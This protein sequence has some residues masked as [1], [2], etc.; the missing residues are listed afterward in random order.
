ML[1]LALTEEDAGRAERFFEIAK[2]MGMR[3]KVTLSKE[4]QLFCKF[5]SAP[6]KMQVFR[7]E[8]G[9]RIILCKSCGKIRKIAFT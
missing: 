9:K 6:P 2:K 7:T 5:C 1:Q 8:D 3:N 4:K